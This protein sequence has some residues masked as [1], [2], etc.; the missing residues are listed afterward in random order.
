MS[1]RD[2][3]FLVAVTS[4]SVYC[5]PS[6]PSRTPGGRTC[7]SSD[8]RCGGGRAFGPVDAA[9]PTWIPIRRSGTSLSARFEWHIHR[10]GGRSSRPMTLG[11]GSSE[12]RIGSIDRGRPTRQRLIRLV[13]SSGDRGGGRRPVARREV[14]PVG[15][16]RP[17]SPDEGLGLDH[18]EYADSS[19]R[20]SGHP[21]VG[22]SA[23]PVGVA[24][25]THG[26]TEPLNVARTVGQIRVRDHAVA[27]LVWLPMVTAPFVYAAPNG[28]AGR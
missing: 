1:S 5:R 24:D 28:G 10:T 14:V 6:C 15:V 27:G 26:V 19:G 25:P 12:E 16:A 3:R 2:V 20:H 23:P 4:T 7:V 11:S 22:M 13:M 21:I 18:R 9:A 17:G 8:L